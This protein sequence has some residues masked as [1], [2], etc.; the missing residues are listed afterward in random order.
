MSNHECGGHGRRMYGKMQRTQVYSDLK[1]KIIKNDE[2][3]S[4]KGHVINNAISD[5]ASRI[6][7]ITTHPYSTEMYADST[8]P[9]TDYLP[10]IPKN[11]RIPQKAIDGARE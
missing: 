2:R 7:T 3:L 4:H 9:S 10:V 11:L 6:S 8:T 5:L 1:K